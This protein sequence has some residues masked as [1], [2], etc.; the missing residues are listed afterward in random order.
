MRDLRMPFKPINRPVDSRPIRPP[1]SS[2]GQPPVR[3]F[4]HPKLQP[5]SLSEVQS[6]RQQRYFPAYS[7]N[8][9]SAQQSPRSYNRFNQQ[10]QRPQPQ[11]QRRP[12]NLPNNEGPRHQMYNSQASNSAPPHR[13]PFRQSSAASV[14]VPSLHAGPSGNLLPSFTNKKT[15]SPAVQG[16]P[17]RN[18]VIDVFHHIPVTQR[19]THNIYPNVPVIPASTLGPHSQ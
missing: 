2:Q 15:A 19:P 8:H 13:M 1:P 14:P 6:Q 7:T 11:P 18:R 16:N 10:I 9:G 5:V 3:A 12:V 17:T 4:T